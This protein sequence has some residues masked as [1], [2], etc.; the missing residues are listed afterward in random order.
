MNAVTNSSEWFHRR[1]PWWIG[2]AFSY[3]TNPRSDLRPTSLMKIYSHFGELRK[4]GF[5][6]LLV[7]QRIARARFFANGLGLFGV[8]RSIAKAPASDRRRIA[9]LVRLT[10]DQ[11]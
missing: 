11:A 3:S 6:M 9:D 10:F 8:G 2:H 7:E 1:V 4:A 5:T